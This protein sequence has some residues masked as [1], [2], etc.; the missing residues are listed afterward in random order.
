MWLPASFATHPWCQAVLTSGCHCVASSLTLYP[1]FA[2]HHFTICSSYSSFPGP[3]PHCLLAKLRLTYLISSSMG[4]NHMA[5]CGCTGWPR[6]A[7]GSAG[8]KLHR[9]AWAAAL[10]R[11][12][13]GGTTQH[14]CAGGTTH[15]GSTAWTTLRRRWS[16]APGKRKHFSNWSSSSS[17]SSKN[18]P[19]LTNSPA[20]L[21]F[22]PTSPIS[23]PTRAV[24][25]L[26]SVAVPR[27][28]PPA[29]TAD[30]TGRFALRRAVP[31]R[32]AAPRWRPN[33]DVRKAPPTENEGFFFLKA[34]SGDHFFGGFF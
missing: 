23:V 13:L 11:R 14:W 22:P 34:K 12:V 15:P 28:R 27:R 4:R 9:A 18:R 7:T 16:T 30:V 26:R 21:L 29:P 6:S 33:S 31:R 17:S 25:P 20:P 19:N 3:Y 5:L 24:S 2:P 8:P 32:D 10:L 1:I